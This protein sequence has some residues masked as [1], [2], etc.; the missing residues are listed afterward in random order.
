MIVIELIDI[1][2]HNLLTIDASITVMI[3]RALNYLFG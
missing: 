3:A 2:L 1:G